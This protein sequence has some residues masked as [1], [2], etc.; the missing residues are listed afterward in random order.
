MALRPSLET[1]FL[2]RHV[3]VLGGDGGVALPVCHIE[4]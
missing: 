2:Q 3:L 4:D 1:G